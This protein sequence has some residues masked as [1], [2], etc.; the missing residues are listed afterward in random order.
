MRL[1]RIKTNNMPFQKSMNGRGLKPRRGKGV[2]NFATNRDEDVARIIEK[3]NQIQ[4]RGTKKKTKNHHAVALYHHREEKYT[5]N[6]RREDYK[7]EP[8]TRPL[9]VNLL[10]GLVSKI[11]GRI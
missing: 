4:R 2:A 7:I 9:T 6:L 8:A 5:T 11:Q 10:A 1:G 3:K